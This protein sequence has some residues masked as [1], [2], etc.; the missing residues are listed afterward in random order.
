MSPERDKRSPPA[1][2]RVV[3]VSGE[4]SEEA[5][6]DVLRGFCRRRGIR[7][8]LR[9]RFEGYSL[10]ERKVRRGTAALLSG[11][12]AVE[13]KKKGERSVFESFIYVAVE[14]IRLKIRQ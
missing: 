12:A 6:G 9:Q 1:T 5:Y 11:F 3:C 2:I 4:G 14:G 7:G 10:P 13:V 8:G